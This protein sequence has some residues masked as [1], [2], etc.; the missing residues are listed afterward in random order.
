MKKSGFLLKIIPDTFIPWKWAKIS[1]I[2]FFLKLMTLTQKEVFPM[3]FCHIPVKIVKRSEGR[4]AVEAAAYR[5]GTKLTN[6]WDGQTHDYTRKRGVVHTEIMLRPMPRQ[7][8]KTAP[9][10]GT[11]WSRLRKQRTASLPAT[12]RR[13]CPV[14]FRENSS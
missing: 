2:V 3:D 9:L 11:A 14:S 13:P 6:E 12:S 8:F 5:S 7:S 4:S 10:S 1:G